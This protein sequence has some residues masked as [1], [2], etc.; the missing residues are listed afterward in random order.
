M[1]AANRASPPLA[2]RISPT[3]RT[4]ETKKAYSCETPRRR[5]LTFAI[6]SAAAAFASA[7][8]SAVASR[9]SA[10]R[11]TA[12]SRASATAAFASASC[13]AAASRASLN[14]S[15]GLIDQ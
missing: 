1:P 10:T 6:C 15:M 8:F 13:S 2:R 11:S 5:G 9:A 7:S 3:P 12:V 14:R 4:S